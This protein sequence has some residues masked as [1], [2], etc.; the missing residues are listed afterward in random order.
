[1]AK[2]RTQEAF[3][4]M[5][6]AKALEGEVQAWVNQGWPGITQTT[7]E[8]F[9][10]WFQRGEDIEERFYDCQKRLSIAVKY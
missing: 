1:M 8:L 6:L 4:Y 7:V 10:Y 5:H 9:N 2:I 3:S